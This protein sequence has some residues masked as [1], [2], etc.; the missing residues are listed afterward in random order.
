MNFGEALEQLKE[1]KKVARKGWNGKGMFIYLTQGRTIDAALW[2]G[3]K[4]C[5]KYKSERGKSAAQPVVEILSHIDM[6]TAD[7]S[8]CIGWLASQ[9]D[10]I[11]EDWV[12]V[13]EE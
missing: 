12:E 1:G 8:V 6:R 13:P 2:T 3:D 9:T 11:S 4:D 10:M 7:G 5:I